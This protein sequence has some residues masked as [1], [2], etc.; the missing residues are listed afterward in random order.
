MPYLPGSAQVNR[1]KMTMIP[2][3]IMTNA[4]MGKTVSSRP[5]V[6]D[7]IVS[8]TGRLHSMLDAGNAQRARALPP[9]ALAIKPVGMS[10]RRVPL[11]PV[12]TPLYL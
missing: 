4:V 2:Y 5:C 9:V 6:G 7:A 10:E 1:S 3:L 8:S 12:P 11:I